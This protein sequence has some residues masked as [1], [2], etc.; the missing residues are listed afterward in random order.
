MITHALFVKV[1]SG[2]GDLKSPHVYLFPSGDQAVSFAIVELIKARELVFRKGVF[3]VAGEDYGHRTPSQAL[4]E[5][6]NSLS[7]SEYF[8][9]YDITDVTPA[10]KECN[11][12][13]DDEVATLKR[14]LKDA[15]VA[16][17]ALLEDMINYRDASEKIVEQALRNWPWLRPLV[18]CDD[19]I[20]PSGEGNSTP[21]NRTQQR[22][23]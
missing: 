6:Q 10:Q 3:V 4:R 2:L 23:P 7:S 11:K 14:K 18:G 13:D 9:I 1:D 21:N 17:V 22:G 20:K 16:A 5:W 15:N 12:S 8:H 19:S